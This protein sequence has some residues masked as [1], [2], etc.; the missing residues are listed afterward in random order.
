MRFSTNASMVFT[1]FYVMQKLEIENLI[2]IIEGVRYGTP[3]ENIEK[4]LI[5]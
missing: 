3:S 4:M 1:T 5:Y 2:N